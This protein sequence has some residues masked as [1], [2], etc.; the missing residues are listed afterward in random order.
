[1][2]NGHQIYFVLPHTAENLR[3]D[4]NHPVKFLPGFA[5]ASSFQPFQVQAGLSSPYLTAETYLKWL[6]AKRKE[7]PQQ[8]YGTNLMQEVQRYALEAAEHAREISHDII[9]SHDWLT[10]HAGVEAQ[11]ISGQPHLLH[12]HATEF[13][14]A[15]ENPN[16]A[17]YDLERS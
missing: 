13:D 9:H 5:S 14:R 10:A 4:A 12:I 11:K 8:N 17:I 1:M 3:M 15:G 2:S 7:N 6:E 16:Q